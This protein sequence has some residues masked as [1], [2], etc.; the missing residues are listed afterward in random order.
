MGSVNLYELMYMSHFCDSYAQKALFC[1]FKPVVL[2]MVS[3][4]VPR[5]SHLYTY[6]EDIVQEAMISVFDALDRYRGDRGASPAT[7][8]FMAVKRKISSSKRR[9]STRTYQEYTDS[10]G[11]PEEFDKYS[12]LVR[13]PVNT[14]DP[15][16]MM[17]FSEAAKRLNTLYSQLKEEDRELM[18]SWWSGEKNTDFA[19]RTGKP[20]ST[21]SSRMNRL[22]QQ[23]RRAVKGEL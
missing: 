15:V 2:N 21:I 16:Y 11:C 8:V 3:E 4:S 7:F 6:R 12:C 9:Y 22:K 23:V 17:E 19:R 18:R 10:Y 1:F 20:V 5:S 14:Y 13:E